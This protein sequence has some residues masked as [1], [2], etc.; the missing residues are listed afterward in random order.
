MKTSSAKAKGRRLQQWVCAQISS[1]TGI[2]WGPD[3][4]IASREMGQGGTDVRLVGDAL[5]RF[6]FAVE[7]KYQETWSI[8][9]WVKQAK[10]NLEEDHLTYLLFVKRNRHE[11]LVVM[12]A[13]FFFRL[14]SGKKGGILT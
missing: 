10:G 12:D 2:P 1:I 14:W 9:Q 4:P 6:P 3:Q 8:P 11:E 5:D 13:R 7:C